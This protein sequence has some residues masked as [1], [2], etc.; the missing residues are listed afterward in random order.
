MA[1]TYTTRT[2]PANDPSVLTDVRRFVAEAAAGVSQ[3]VVQDLQLAVTEA[4]ANA[5]RHSGTEEVRV[6]I[7]VLDSCVEVTIEDDGV[8]LERLPPAEGDAY[9]HRG[10]FLMVAMV[11]ELSVK[12]G[13]VEQ[14]G[15]TVRLVKCSA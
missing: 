3:P 7:R 11:D 1:E 15:T 13:T 8:Y 10:I 4:C 6:S 5:I 12:R 9:G 14:L 2:F